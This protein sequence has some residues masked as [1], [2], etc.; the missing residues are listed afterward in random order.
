[1]SR[2]KFITKN[3]KYVTHIIRRYTFPS[4]NDGLASD[5]VW[6]G[7]TVAEGFALNI[8]TVTDTAPV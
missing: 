3:K 6:F 7:Y 8:L 2:K 4:L 1:M 5:E